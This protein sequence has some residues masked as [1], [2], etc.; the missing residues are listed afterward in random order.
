MEGW[1]VFKKQRSECDMF[2]YFCALMY[3]LSSYL[4]RA[5][6]EKIKYCCCRA[7]VMAEGAKDTT[8]C[9]LQCQYSCNQAQ[10]LFLFVLRSEK[11]TVNETCFLFYFLLPQ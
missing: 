10:S 3:F 6:A 4:L 11:N 1:F 8:L 9:F 5:I 7:Y 2:L